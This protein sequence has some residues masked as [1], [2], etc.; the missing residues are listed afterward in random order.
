MQRDPPFARQHQVGTGMS[1]VSQSAP[2]D[3]RSSK[4][5]LVEAMLDYA[6]IGA[7]ELRLP[8]L[9]LMLRA[10]RLELLNSTAS[11]PQ[12]AEADMRQ[13]GGEASPRR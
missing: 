6:M 2:Q 11:G 8:W 13:A 5:G 1:S 9:V 12:G 7:A 10:A 3:E 4:I